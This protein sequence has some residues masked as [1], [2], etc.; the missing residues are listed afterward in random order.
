LVGVRRPQRIISI[1]ARDDPDV[2][3]DGEDLVDE[4]PDEE[5]LIDVS[6]YGFGLYEPT[7]DGIFARTLRTATS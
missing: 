2:E 6:R 7:E 4:R 3:L 1:S 5:V